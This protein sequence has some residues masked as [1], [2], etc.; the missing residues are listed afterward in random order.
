MGWVE[1][2]VDTAPV[3][4]ASHCPNPLPDGYAACM[5][6]L[7]GSS[8]AHEWTNEEWDAVRHMPRLPVWVPT[9]GVDNPRQSA[10]ACVRRLAELGVP[11]ADQQGGRHVTVLWDLETGTE[12][13]PGWANHAAD[14][15]LAHGYFNLIYG[16]TAWI[17]GNPS[18]AGYVVADPTGSAHM[19]LHPD[20]SG[21]QYAW[22]IQTAG[23]AIDAS[24]FTLDAIA[25]FWR[26]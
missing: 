4:D 22:G 24:L 10:L 21:T 13:D 18:R 5:G 15:L 8:A 3:W 25:K 9:P 2:E 16:S 26:P 1:A 23:G 17:F 11:R 7:G 12:P 14:V 6:Y 20:V 19:Y